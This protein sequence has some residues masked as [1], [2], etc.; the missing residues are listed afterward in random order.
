[1][2]SFA[3]LVL[4]FTACY[5]SV[6]F[7]FALL[8]VLIEASVLL[9]IWEASTRGGK[10]ANFLFF[11]GN[12]LVAAVIGY[13]SYTPNNMR[14]GT[15]YLLVGNV[16]HFSVVWVFV[17]LKP[18]VAPLFHPKATAVVVPVARV[19][20]GIECGEWCTQVDVQEGVECV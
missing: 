13:A 20:E 5:L 16:V 12:V 19:A 17:C 4:V 8:V 2:W 7:G 10:R 18:I 11:G 3:L 9:N 14:D 15:L 6:G 1:M